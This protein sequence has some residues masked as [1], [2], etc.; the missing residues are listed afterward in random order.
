MPHKSLLHLQELLFHYPPELNVLCSQGVKGMRNCGLLPVY[1]SYF[2]FAIWKRDVGKKPNFFQK[3]TH[4]HPPAGPCKLEWKK[5]DCVSITSKRA[6]WE[7]REMGLWDRP[8][9]TPLAPLLMNAVSPFSAFV[10][11]LQK[12]W[13]PG[14]HH[15]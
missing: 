12:L 6:S 10:T 2:A 4:E 5:L 3:D 8:T 7:N 9:C 14:L 13:F 15:A 11:L 1:S